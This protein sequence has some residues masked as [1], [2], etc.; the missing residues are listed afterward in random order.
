MTPRRTKHPPSGLGKRLKL[1]RE[2]AGLDDVDVAAAAGLCRTHVHSLEVGWIL[3]PRYE[4]VLALSRVLG[5]PL[6]YLLAGQG[7]P[8]SSSEVMAAFKRARR[9]SRSRARPAAQS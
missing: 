5:A 1:V 9:Q 8:P 2:S 4:T 3:N 7:Q 6:D